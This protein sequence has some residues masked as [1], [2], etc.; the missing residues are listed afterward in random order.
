MIDFDQLKELNK[1]EEVIEE[2]GKFPLDHKGMANHM[3]SKGHGGFV[4]DTSRQYYY[5]NTQG[6]GG[7][8]IDYLI[9]E[10]NMDIQAAAHFLAKRAGIDLNLTPAQKAAYH[11]KQERGTILD[12]LINFFHDLLL[13]D[14]IGQAYLAKRGWSLDTAKSERLGYW[15]QRHRPA[16][17]K[18]LL[19]HNISFDHP[20][21]VAVLGFVGDINQWGKRWKVSPKKSWIENN[22]IPAMWW[23]DQGMLIYSSF[24]SGRGDYFSARA[25]GESTDQRWKHWKP[26]IELLGKQRPFFNSAAAQ[27]DFVILVEGQADMITLSQWA[28]PAVAIAGLADQLSLALKLASYGRVFIGLDSDQA[29]Q[30]ALSTDR[31]LGRLLDQIGGTAKVINW[32]SKDCNDWLLAGGTADECRQLLGRSPTYAEA[33]AT[34]ASTATLNDRDNLQLHALKIASRLPDYDHAIL[35]DTIAKKLGLSIRQYT[36][37]IKALKSVADVNK[38]IAAENDLN[39]DDLAELLKEPADHEGHAQTCY[40]LNNKGFAFVPKWGWLA[41]TGKYWLEENGEQAVDRAITETLR[42]RYEA[43]EAVGRDELAAASKANKIQRVGT[44]GQ[45][46][47]IAAIATDRFD[48]Y[49]YLLNVKNGVIDLRTG[50][51]LAHNPDQYFTYCLDINYDPAAEDQD[52]TWLSFLSQVIGGEEK[53]HL[54]VINFLQEAA[55]YTL[56]GLSRE[57][58]LFYLY[59]QTAAGKGVF[60]ETLSSIL[61]K[62]LGQ[63]VNFKTFTSERTGDTQ[64]FD[65]APLR[66]ARL[67]WAD[68]GS[69]HSRANEEQLKRMTGGGEIWCSHKGKPHFSYLPQFTIWLT[70]NYPLLMAPEDMAAWQRVFV[71]HFPNSFAGKEDKNLKRRLLETKSLE[72]VLAWCVTGAKRWYQRPEGL[73]P[74]A[75]VKSW[76]DEMKNDQ[77]MVGFFLIESC[78]IHD[79]NN[80]DVFSPLELLT[81]KY[82]DWCKNM[83]IR[84][85][86]MPALRASLEA[87][88]YERARR[89]HKMYDNPRIGFNGILIKDENDPGV[90]AAAAGKNSP[91]NI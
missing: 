47:S 7:T 24:D 66:A 33:L 59:G 83:S 20:L 75:I 63:T 78:Q 3:R 46:E 26:P 69:S 84:A 73:V 41:Y 57:R 72:A 77:D 14:P 67:V 49:P 68:E 8:V 55:G 9:N 80:K 10:H 32:P 11:A 38:I 71:I 17:E 61:K 60:M 42:R 30:R 36:A 86:G 35:R 40:K 37:A 31:P 44:K 23:G 56:T 62:P 65:L 4:V 54:E 39:E 5:W 74:P 2:L 25:I 15:H 28:L 58:A 88:G 29:G 53:E 79:P 45:L 13:D 16:L 81:S 64:N 82:K 34:A 85:K 6:R 48:A 76:V 87:K 90:N 89:R 22:K 51:L 18:R 21:A 91:L 70:S 1:I 27:S 12:T 43:A 50:D 52:Y 19:L